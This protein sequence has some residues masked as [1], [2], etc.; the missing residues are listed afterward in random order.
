MNVM[1]TGGG[2]LGEAIT[3]AIVTF[4]TLLAAFI[5]VL[6]VMARRY[7]NTKHAFVAEASRRREARQTVAQRS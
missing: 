2:Y 5:A 3:V 1:G 7:H 4:L 6:V